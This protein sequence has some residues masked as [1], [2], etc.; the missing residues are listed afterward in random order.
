[1]TFCHNCGHKL[2]LG[3]ERFCPNCGANLQAV[4]E[5]RKSDVV[6]MGISDTKG[7]VLG[8]GLTGS[9]NII[10]KE[11]GY[12]VQGNYINLQIST[13]SKEVLDGLQKIIA[14]PT[15]VDQTLSKDTSTT[16]QD[17]VEKESSDAQKQIKN[18]LEEVSKIEQKTGIEIQGI[19]AGDLQISKNELS[20]KEYILKGN[21]HSYKK[22]YNEAIRW[23]DKAIEI[24]YNNFDLWF[25]KGNALDELGKY[26][27]AIKCY[28]KA[29]E[30]NPNDVYAWNNKGY[31]LYSLG[32]KVEAIKC[33][34]KALELNPGNAL[35]YENRNNLLNK[36]NSEP[37]NDRIHKKKKR[38]FGR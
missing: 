31:S 25:N 28:D 37:A 15:Q 9:G 29:L 1:M 13:M 12:T 8:A 11:V 38:W 4:S 21:E 19:K 14:V 32:N 23:Y 27:E 35:A 20:S 18:V 3:T 10:G 5:D 16:N 7:D 22:E 33:Y 2:N 26:K 24:D 6:T 36:R 30:L 17:N 34:D